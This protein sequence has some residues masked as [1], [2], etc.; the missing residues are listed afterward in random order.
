MELNARSWRVC[1]NLYAS[2]DTL[3]ITRIDGATGWD[4]G[5]QCVGGLQA[6][7][8]LARI[9][10]ADLADIQLV[11]TDLPGCGL[12]V[13]VTTDH[14]FRACMDSQY[15]G[16]KI[17]G[18]GY[19]AMGSG[20]MRIA[21]AQEAF[22]EGR[23]RETTEVAVGVLEADRFPPPQIVQ[24]IAETCQVA[25]DRLCLLVAQTS[26]LA[27][28]LQVVARSLETA[29]HKLM[30]LGFDLSRIVSG[31]GT[32]PLPPGSKDD[33]GAIGRTNDAILYGGRVTI[34]VRGDDTSLEETIPQV[35]SA[36]SRD[37]GRPFAEIFAEYDYDFY[38]IDP[39]LFS[40]ASIRVVNLDTGNVFQAGRVNR[41]VLATSFQT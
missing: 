28:T 31:Y 13:Q 32:A 5:N 36:A 21:A 7:L 9:C 17:T 6:G 11:P 37:Y 34:W 12:S 14:P 20:P 41:D 29:M 3:R 24:E 22:F 16:W 2:S 8:Q 39:H 40:P 27:G 10:T 26:S 38:Q 35:P 30:D 4:F 23:Q 19:F 25:P 1:Q 33:L 18:D 15:A